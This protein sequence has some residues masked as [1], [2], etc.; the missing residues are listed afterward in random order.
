MTLTYV[1]EGDSITL[2]TPS[3]PPAEVPGECST[4]RCAM[5]FELTPTG[6]GT[7]V[8]DAN[9]R[10]A[11]PELTLRAGPPG[12]RL[13]APGGSG[14]GTS[15]VV[16]MVSGGGRLS[17][18]SSVDGRSDATLGLRNLGDTPLP[19]LELALVWPSAR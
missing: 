18:S 15:R 19:V 4:G 13:P 9:G 17:I 5:G 12:T 2:V 16:A 8:L 6:S 10:G 14:G 1:P 11:R 3:L 7:F